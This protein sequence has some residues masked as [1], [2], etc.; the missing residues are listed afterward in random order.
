MTHSY[1]VYPVVFCG[2]YCVLYCILR[3]R[4]ISMR[5]IVCMTLVL[6]MCW[7]MDLYVRNK[8]NDIRFCHFSYKHKA[9]T[10][11]T[12]S[13]EFIVLSWSETAT[14]CTDCTPGMPL[15]CGPGSGSMV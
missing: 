14:K 15:L 9:I 2:H 5:S 10:T 11:T 7:C 4:G 8:Y 1:R 6:T 3:S 12:D 13:R